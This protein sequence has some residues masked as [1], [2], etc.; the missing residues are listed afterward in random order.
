M[1]IAFLRGTL[2]SRE[3]SGGPADRLV[4]DVG[5]VGFEA[6]VARSTSA[7]AGELG[8]EVTIHTS[9][10]IRENEWQLFGFSL[11][12]EKEMFGLLQS[13]TGVGPKMA[14]SLV[15]TLGPQ[16][17]AEAIASEDHKTLSQAPGVG[18]KVAQRM[19]LE[20]KS[21]TEEWQ[22][23]RG[24]PSAPAGKSASRDE[25]RQILEELG[26]TLTEINHAFKRLGDDSSDDDVEMLV[27][28]SLKVL[29][30]S[31]R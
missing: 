1:V 2:Q 24:T 9:L 13:V 28:Q 27:R 10:S 14:L 29:G 16:R 19:I 30:T 5:G 7:Q 8:D 18:P 22:I 26:Y 3:I 25:A 21:K 11:A 23:R 20:L 4:I 17:I 6:L 12:E 31:E 15:G